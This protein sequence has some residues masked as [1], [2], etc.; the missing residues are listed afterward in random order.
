ML[1]G[2]Q[3]YE[4]SEVKGGGWLADLYHAFPNCMFFSPGSQKLT[5]VV[6]RQCLMAASRAVRHPALCNDKEKP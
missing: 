6:Y 1:P 5:T 4:K 3:R 2:D